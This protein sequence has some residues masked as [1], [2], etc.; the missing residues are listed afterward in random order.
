MKRIALKNSD[1]FA[2]VDDVDFD[3]LSQFNWFDTNGYALANMM[4]RR[5]YMH[6]AVANTPDDMDTDHINR[7][8]LDNRRRNLRV[9]SRSENLKFRKAYSKSGYKYVYYMQNRKNPWVV[10]IAK[11]NLGY[12]SSAI[13]AHKFAKGII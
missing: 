11:K 3:Y 1:K 12:F 10:Q 4:G 2:V 9:C 5:V 8:K 13:E 7:D 6:R